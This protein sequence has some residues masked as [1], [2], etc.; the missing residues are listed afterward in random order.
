MLSKINE[1]PDPFVSYVSQA[2]SPASTYCSMN[3]FMIC[4]FGLFVAE[5]RPSKL[6][7]LGYQFE[8]REQMHDCA[9]WKYKERSI[10]THQIL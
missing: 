10:M 3:N 6:E 4:W 2:F 5:I 8:Y 7:E 1:W 9:A